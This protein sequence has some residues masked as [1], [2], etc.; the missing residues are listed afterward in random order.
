MA[1]ST[2]TGCN[3]ISS[4]SLIIVGAG[5]H[6]RAVAEMVQL[7]GE[8]RPVGYLDDT[9]VAGERID[10]LTVRGRAAMLRASTELAQWAI[11]AIGDNVAREHYQALARRAGFR[12]ATIMHPQAIVAGSARIG[13]GTTIMAGAVIASGCQLGKGVIV[14]CG[15]TVDNRSVL[16]DYAHIGTGAAIAGGSRIRRAAW[17]RAGCAIGY[18]A[19]VPAN[20]M[21]PPGTVLGE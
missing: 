2:S 1:K 5:R 18:H 20:A 6:G 4:E 13:A 11:I 17:L 16:D 8:L 10:G 19:E 9:R 3:L 12:V 14:N 21:L 7:T 15:A